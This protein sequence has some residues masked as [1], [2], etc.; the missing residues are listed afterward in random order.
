MMAFVTFAQTGNL[1]NIDPVTDPPGDIQ[2]SARMALFKKKV[3]LNRFLHNAI[4]ATFAGG[5]PI[6]QVDPSHVLTAEQ[7]IEA[8]EILRV[9]SL[10][11]HYF[12]LA[13]RVGEG[14]PVDTAELGVRYQ[15]VLWHVLVESARSRPEAEAIARWWEVGVAEV[16]TRL[17]NEAAGSPEALAE[18]TAAT[19]RILR[20]AL[21]TDD[22]EYCRKA[23]KMV[24][25][26]SVQA[27]TFALT[28]V[29][30]VS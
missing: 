1:T 26:H 30:L 10:V 19:A 17:E 11:A 2:E 25:D 3:Q 9:Q 28:E 22:D 14:I 5:F 20:K 21:N 29:M 15:D 12:A 4:A 24:S 27:L 6:S 8:A 18:V 16:V 7:R 23:A 13:A